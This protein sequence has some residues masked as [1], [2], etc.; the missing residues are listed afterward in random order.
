MEENPFDLEI[1]YKLYLER[2]NLKEHEMHPIQRQETKRAFYGACGQ[3]LVVLR[4]E[5]GPLDMDLGI[6]ALDSMHDQVLSFW[7]KQ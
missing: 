7:E 3:I 4:D 6:E 1:Q 2:V 5:V